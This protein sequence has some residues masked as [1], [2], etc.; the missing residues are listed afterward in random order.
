M[1]LMKKYQN[2]LKI[3]FFESKY[4]VKSV[5]SKNYSTQMTGGRKRCIQ[6]LSVEHA[7]IL[8]YTILYFLRLRV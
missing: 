8:Y 7:N 4:V 2:Q 3:D 6:D 1:K 5:K